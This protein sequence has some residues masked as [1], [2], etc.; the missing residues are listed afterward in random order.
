M[1]NLILKLAIQN[2]TSLLLGC[3][4]HIFVVRPAIGR[5]GHPLALFFC[6]NSRSQPNFQI[7]RGN[8]IYVSVKMQPEKMNAKNQCSS[9]VKPG[10]QAE[11]WQKPIT[12]GRKI[13]GE[14][15]EKRV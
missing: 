12:I 11:Q 15:T 1:S 3:T 4:A 7:R 14:R 13:L 8:S 10:L 6:P 2:F 9:V 5:P